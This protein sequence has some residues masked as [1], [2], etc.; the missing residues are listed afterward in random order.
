MAP[1]VKPR[2][3]ETEEI[4]G[5][6]WCFSSSEVLWSYTHASF[7]FSEQGWHVWS[8]KILPPPSKNKQIN[9][10]NKASG[11]SRHGKEYFLA[12]FFK[13]DLGLAK[14]LLVWEP[15]GRGTD[16]N[17]RTRGKG[18]LGIHCVLRGGIGDGRNRNLLQSILQKEPGGEKPRA[19]CSG[20][21]GLGKIGKGWARLH[22]GESPREENMSMTET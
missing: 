3:L 19:P 14:A 10:N 2:G 7:I 16:T 17:V 5:Y 4:H 8:N 15:P 20:E 22:G 1:A 12:H 13:P 11:S 21:A 9:N 18:L 6:T